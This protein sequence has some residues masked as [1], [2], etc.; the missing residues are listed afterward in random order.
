[1]Q[2]TK[3]IGAEPAIGLKLQYAD[4]DNE[5]DRAAELV[6]YCNGHPETTK[7]GRLRAARGHPEPFGV[8]KF[9]LGNEAGVGPTPSGRRAALCR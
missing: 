8:K 2:L 7:G 1:M 6:E 9:Y 5:V 3:L 4:R